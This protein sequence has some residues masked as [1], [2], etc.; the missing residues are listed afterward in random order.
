MCPVYWRIV[1][2]MIPY[3]CLFGFFSKVSRK[4]TPRKC[5]KSLLLTASSISKLLRGLFGKIAFSTWII[6]SKHC[7]SGNNTSSNFMYV[8]FRFVVWERIFSNSASEISLSVNAFEIMLRIELSCS[9][10]KVFASHVSEF[11][12]K[13]IFQL[14]SEKLKHFQKTRSIHVKPSQK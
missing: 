14:L 4:K 7:F 11:C 12:W 3:S 1:K 10:I 9:S 2:V 6:Y 13:G 8:S 5:F